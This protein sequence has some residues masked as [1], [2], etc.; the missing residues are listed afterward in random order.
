[1]KENENEEIEN[2]QSNNIYDYN[3]IDEGE[4]SDDDEVENIEENFS[5]RIAMHKIKDYLMM[6]FLFLSS[7]VNFSILYIPCIILGIS[8]IFILLKHIKYT[9][10]LNQIEI[11]IEIISLVYSLLLLIIKSIFFGMILN[12]IIDFSSY[13][14]IL[15]NLGIKHEKDSNIIGEIFI[16]FIGE[17]A[18]IIIS[19]IAIIIS[20][21]NKKIDS[22][23]KI[24][25][26]CMEKYYNSF[27]KEQM[28]KKI[29]TIMILAYFS[30]LVNSIY[31]KS[32]LTLSY[33]LSYQFLLII[34]ILKIK[35]YSLF[36]IASIIYLVFYTLQLFLINIFNIYYLQQKLLKVNIIKDGDKIKKVYSIY[37]MIGFNYS[38]YHSILTFLYE[39]LSYV[40]CVLTIVLFTINQRIFKEKDQINVYN[41]ISHKENKKA[42]KGICEKVKIALTN[43]FTDL[44]FIL[45][46]FRIISLLWIYTLRNIYSF[47][48]FIFIFF[49]FIFDGMNKIQYII[50]FVLIPVNFL[51]L[52]CL[53]FSNID[54]I[55][56]NIKERKKEIFSD[57]SYEKDETNLE[58]ILVGIYYLFIIS[59]LNSY[60]SKNNIIKYR[61]LDSIFINITKNQNNNKIPL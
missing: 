50:I 57:L 23:E 33:I 53:H 7:S 22:D 52:G 61:V 39:W 26:E 34:I 49:S 31:N 2:N 21:V 13:E 27:T 59:F 60:N 36:R 11:K 15:N 48:I 47:G 3:I 55:S 32:F 25:K 58:Y 40:A 30:I 44:E 54:G 28:D 35:S 14:N 8:Y 42:E 19:I 38:Y 10:D 9:N 43:F 45:F 1:M 37:T 56:E 18:L 51:S 5:K 29:K 16:C 41:D 17:I 6:I 4:G 46:F 20:C 24:I 12:D